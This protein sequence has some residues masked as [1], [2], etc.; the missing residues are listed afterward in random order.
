LILKNEIKL[1]MMVALLRE[2][3]LNPNLHLYDFGSGGWSIIYWAC[4]EGVADV[5]QYLL[6]T[7]EVDCF[8][9]DEQWSTST[10]LW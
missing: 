9:T 5:V 3:K 1:K 10:A 2:G 6:S 8:Q 4:A 7:D